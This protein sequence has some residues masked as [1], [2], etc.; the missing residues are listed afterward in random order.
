MEDVTGDFCQSRF[1]GFTARGMGEEEGF[2]REGRQ[3]VHL[4]LLI[5]FRTR[6]KIL[7][8]EVTRRNNL[9]PN[10][11][12]ERPKTQG[13]QTTMSN[14]VTQPSVM[15]P[16][17]PGKPNIFTSFAPTLLSDTSMYGIQTISSSSPLGAAAERVVPKTVVS[18][19][20]DK[21]SCYC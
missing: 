8:R 2:V 4:N 18:G 11:F 7:R 16:P 21:G 20:K 12:C 10:Q 17:P 14:T 15:P 5:P 13:R 3:T 1:F 6:L 19:W 9:P